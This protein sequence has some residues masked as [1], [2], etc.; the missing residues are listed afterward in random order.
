MLI[1][2]W[3]KFGGF[4]FFNGYSKRICLG[5]VA[6]TFIPIEIDEIIKP[7]QFGQ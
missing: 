4:Y 5:W 1:F 6:I 3:G 7:D 2:S